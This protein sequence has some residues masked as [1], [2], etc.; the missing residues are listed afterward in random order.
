[1]KISNVNFFC[2]HYQL[3]PQ[4]TVPTLVDEDQS[5]WDSHAI[6]AYLVDKYAPDD[7]LYPKDLITRARVDQR[8][9]FDSGVLFPALRGANIPIFT[10]A[11]EVPAEKLEAISAAYDL[12][13]TFLAE[14]EY[15]VG[16]SVTIADLC[17]VATVTV[18]ELHQPLGDE[19]HPKTREWITRLS[20][21]PYYED[22]ITRV[23]EKFAVFLDQKKAAAAEE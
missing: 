21:L 11:K 15:L 19:Q 14:D 22:L 20:E 12:L 10:G 5:I 2:C 7:S 3:N 16:N 13:E 6:C 23:V 18:M 9:H 1:M 17:A 4:H 8:L